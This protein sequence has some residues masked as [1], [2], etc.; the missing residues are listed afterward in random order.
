M[1]YHPNKRNNHYASK[2]KNY[3]KILFYILIT[4]LILNVV[5][6]I[7]FII[8]HHK[9]YPNIVVLNQEI[10][11]K[12]KDHAYQILY[13]VVQQAIAQRLIIKHQD[14]EIS[15]IP[16]DDLGISI[17]VQK[18][19]DHAYSVG[20]T[21]TFF[22]RLK[23]RI[24][25]LGNTQELNDLNGCL[26][27]DQNRFQEF[28][29]QLQ[30]QIEVIASDASVNSNR[31]IEAKNGIQIDRSILINKIEKAILDSINSNLIQEVIVPV[32]Y[33]EPDISTNE[34]LEKIGIQYKISTYETYLEGK[35]KN[36]IYN[37][38]K[39]AKQIHGILLD[40][41]AMFS[42]NS[43]VG[44]AEKED[45][46]KESTIIANGHFVNGYGG[47][48]CQVSTTLYNAALLAGLQI[49]ERYHHS[50]YGD[51]TSYVPLGRDSAVYFGQKDLKFKNVLDQK[52]L[53]FCDVTALKLTITI[54]GEKALNQSVDIIS[55]DKKTYNYDI[56][57]VET[58]N[59]DFSKGDIIQEGIPGYSIKI[60]RKIVDSQE[61]R[62]EL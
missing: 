2:N 28:Y 56:I 55:Q 27:F 36:T 43:V 35:E 8:Y 13:P 21:G 32:F 9:I 46:Y 30:P 42:F 49:I 38:Q 62:L 54:F 10:G 48:I 61:E 29:T 17:D 53:L 34:L 58:G 26:I 7:D 51:A 41:E 24:S 18:I 40:P 6:F 44:P 16:K 31:I 50:I 52:L 3:H 14:L 45:G 12:T 19:F 60:Y 23:E 1:Y 37:I 57:E 5:F 47:G 39:A 25:L 33:P 20:R 22:A 4:V 11:Y 15:L 59:S